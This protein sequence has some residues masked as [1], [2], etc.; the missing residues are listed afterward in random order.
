MQTAGNRLAKLSR[1]L[2]RKKGRREE[3]LFLVCGRK[4]IEE[5]MANNAAIE[6]LFVTQDFAE[7]IDSDLHPIIIDSKELSALSPLEIL[8]DAMAICKI[9]EVKSLDI[10]KS[11]VVCDAIS[12]PGNLGT[13]IRLCDWFGVEQLILGRNC[14]DPHN[15]K[16]VQASMGS[17]FRV[18]II[19]C[20]LEDFY[21][22][23][24]SPIYA[25]V[26]EGDNIYE[27]NFDNSPK[28]L[29]L[30]SES[31]GIR[32][33]PSEGN[34]TNLTIPKLGNA[35]SLNVATAGAILLSHMRLA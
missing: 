28:A 11:A 33:F 14:V 26:L 6:H 1:K 32:L 7:N 2:H 15:P 25:A 22:K 16:C 3:S 34:F 9:P 5:A 35:E 23:Y 12:D 27:T 18:N 13:I 8:Q 4:S 24:K 17:I 31:H 30:G 20:D 19:E 21:S 10:H 29:V